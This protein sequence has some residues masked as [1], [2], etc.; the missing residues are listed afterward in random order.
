MPREVKI[1][2][3][4]SK[5]KKIESIEE[6]IRKLQEKKKQLEN[7]M[8]MKVGKAIFDE[9]GIEDDELAIQL[10]KRVKPQITEMLS[11][12]FLLDDNP[13][14]KTNVNEGQHENHKEFSPDKN[15]TE[16]ISLNE[17]QNENTE[18]DPEKVIQYVK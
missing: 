2:A 1:M 11:K 7:K 18:N 13:V 16:K 10:I 14:D 15:P 6:Q 9:W 8:R 4:K 12:E 5:E 17:E 3:R